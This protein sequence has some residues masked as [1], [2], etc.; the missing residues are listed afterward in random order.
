MF[1]DGNGSSVVC[2][3]Q[4]PY[5]NDISLNVV[6]PIQDIEFCTGAHGLP[7]DFGRPSG[8]LI[9]QVITNTETILGNRQ[10]ERPG[11]I[12]NFTGVT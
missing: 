10:C 2:K 11:K 3:E 8:V 4:I 7:S 1:R 5:N 9:S 6:I 12:T